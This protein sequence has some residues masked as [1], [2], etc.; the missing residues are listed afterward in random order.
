[1]GRYLVL[2][3]FL[4][5]STPGK[6][7]ALPTTQATTPGQSAP[8]P[9]GKSI[10]IPNNTH[11][12]GRLLTELDAGE[13]KLGDPVDVEIN[14][15]IT[16]GHHIRVKRGSTLNGHITSVQPFSA[17]ASQ[18]EIAI[19]FD[20]ITLENGEQV[21]LNLQFQALAPQVDV[22]SDTM[23]NGK[24]L[25]G[26]DH[27][28]AV[29]G[30]KDILIANQTEKGER[31]SV[32][33]SKSGNVRLK[34][35]TQ[36][37][38]RVVNRKSSLRETSASP[39]TTTL[40]ESAAFVVPPSVDDF[41]PPV[42]PGV[43]CD[44]PAVLRG[45]GTR[46]SQLVE[47]LEKFSATEHID[48][49][50][51]DSAGARRSEESRSFEY[52][53]TVLQDPISGFQLDEYRNGST[54]PAQFPAGIATEA[55][56]V[57][58]L[59]FHPLLVSDFSM[60]CEGRGQWE[61]RPARQ[62]RFEQRQDR[63][64]R[65]RYYKIQGNYYPV[66]LKGRAWID[67]STSQMLGLETDLVKP[68][69]VIDLAYEHL[70]IEYGEVQ[71]RSKTVQ[72]WLPKTADLYW[73]RHGHRYYRR[74]DFSDFKVFGVETHQNQQLPEGSYSFTNTSSQDVTGVLTVTPIASSKL[75]KVS[76]TF[77]IPARGTILKSLGPGKD[78][79]I[80]GEM[81]EAARFIYKAPEGAVNVDA[82]LPTSS[83]LEVLPE[84]TP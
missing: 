38:L 47:N 51:V 82:N 43:T 1:M 58:A 17:A 24:G 73:E 62:V 30:L 64:N 4:S 55:L 69:K 13:A 8:S 36:L 60:S 40:D 18:S 11:V 50:S 10:S 81:V 65:I 35:G 53:V 20:R 27:E 14:E 25:A 78:V 23:T 61:G 9:P 54:D 75:N 68:I 41:V 59:I 3:A 42:S 79:A 31:V 49:Y 72:L 26:A 37:V 6:I 56:P 57:M 70:S 19:L 2:I 44:L 33:V 63:P 15:D 83:T 46:M 67:V 48:H 76:V 22:K 5:L 84:T 45:V 66:A 52:V 7:F 12:L 16:S 74:H 34:K 80:P 77:V 39:S 29:Y 32:V 28:A 71:F 21:G